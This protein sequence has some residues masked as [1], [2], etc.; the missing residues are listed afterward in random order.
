MINF[1]KENKYAIYG[2][3]FAVYSLGLWHVCSQYT[4]SSYYKERQQ[5]TARALDI[6]N[7]RADL[8][9]L[10]QQELN[11]GLADRKAVQQVIKQETIREIQKEPVYTD[12][13][14]TPTGVQ[15][16]ERA[17]DN[18]GKSSGDVQMPANR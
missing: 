10:I 5:L 14:N 6:S 7:Q 13:R 8:A 17:I 4:S 16:I 3:L 15:L 12:C 9:R 11:K 2:I 18:Y 1:L